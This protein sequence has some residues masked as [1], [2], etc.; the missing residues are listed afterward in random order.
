L[1]EAAARQKNKL[2]SYFFYARF[3]VRIKGVYAMNTSDQLRFDF[4]YQQHLTN[5]TLQGMPPATNKSGV[6]NPITKQFPNSL[7]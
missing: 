6:S 4:L 7:L 2:L 1:N 3:A 5:L